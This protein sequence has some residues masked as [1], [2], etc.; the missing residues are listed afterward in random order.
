MLKSHAAEWVKRLECYSLLT[1][2]PLP[3]VG[4]Q[5]N[6]LAVVLLGFVGLR[7]IKLKPLLVPKMLMI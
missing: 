6:K 7:N 1:N 3:K 5:E 4:P 2:L